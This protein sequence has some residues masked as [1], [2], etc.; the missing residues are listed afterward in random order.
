L[1]GSDP[2]EFADQHSLA[3]STLQAG[4]RKKGFLELTVVTLAA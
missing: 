2:A 4:K 3:L 1:L